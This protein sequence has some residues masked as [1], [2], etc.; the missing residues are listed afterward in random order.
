LSDQQPFRGD[1][2]FARR[3]RFLCDFAPALDYGVDAGEQVL[4]RVVA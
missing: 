1:A 4:A 2:G 3:F